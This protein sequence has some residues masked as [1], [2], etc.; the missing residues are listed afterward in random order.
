[1]KCCEYTTRA[2]QMFDASNPIPMSTRLCCSTSVTG[3]F[4]LVFKNYSEKTSLMVALCG[5]GRRWFE[6]AGKWLERFG[7]RM[8]GIGPIGRIVLYSQLWRFDSGSIGSETLHRV[9]EDTRSQ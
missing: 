6:A 8:I 4:A 2:R 1:M 9:V 3:L 5:S 7:V